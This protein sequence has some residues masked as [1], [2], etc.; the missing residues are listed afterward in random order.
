MTVLTSLS[1]VLHIPL[2]G[3]TTSCI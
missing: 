1:E 2:L 3:R